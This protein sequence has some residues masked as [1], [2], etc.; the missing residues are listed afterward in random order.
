[1]RVTRTSVSMPVKL[2]ADM[3]AVKVPCNWSQIACRAWLE[4]LRQ[5]AF[6]ESARTGIGPSRYPSPWEELLEM[7]HKA[8]REHREQIK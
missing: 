2:K 6:L 7:S 5:I 3:A 4:E 1:M 8:V